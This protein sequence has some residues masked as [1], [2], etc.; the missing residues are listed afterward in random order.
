[1]QYRERRVGQLDL[2][3]AHQ[4]ARFVERELEIVAADLGELALEPQTVQPELRIVPRREDEPH[5]CGRPEQQQLELA[6][7]FV[8]LQLVQVVEDEPE[9]YVGRGQV[10]E[11]PL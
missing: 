4:C 7:R 6:Q 11:Q 10:G 3:A 9:P 5:G 8:G 1:D 2:R